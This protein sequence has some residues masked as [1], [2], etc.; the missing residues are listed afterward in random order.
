MNGRTR[1]SVESGFSLVEM[2]MALAIG[3]IMASVAL[4]MVMGAVQNY[5]LNSVAQQTAILIDLTRYT[6][7]R[8]NMVIKLQKTAQNGNTVLYL[9][10][11][12][13]TK[14]DA[15]EPMVML[16][17]DMQIANGDPLT[18][19]ATNMGLG[20][21][22]D[23]ASQIAFDYRGVVNYGPGV[24]PAPYFLA[25]AYKNQAQYGTRAVTVTPMGQS[26]TW[27]APAGGTW[28]GM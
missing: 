7:I 22:I 9:D 5:R 27:K 8:R 15:G 3:L 21:T 1:R 16:P 26:K 6:A 2:V 19:A 23:F 4:P 14:L 18:P 11:N 17:S 13:N 24:A 12:N 25:I 10:L 28:L 20:S